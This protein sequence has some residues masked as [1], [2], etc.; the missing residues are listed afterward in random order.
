MITSPGTPWEIGTET[1]PI[2][3]TASSACPPESKSICSSAPPGATGLLPTMSMR[4]GRR[5]PSLIGHLSSV[6]A[7]WHLAS[8]TAEHAIPDIGVQKATASR[9]LRGG[10]M[11]P[12]RASNR[13]LYSS[14]VAC[15]V[16]LYLTDEHRR[17]NST[18]AR[19]GRRL[20]CLP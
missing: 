13:C 15:N 18:E 4:T 14:A 10:P 7:G 12:I 11:H 17:V 6:L 9:F 20:T 16:D 19:T 5:R 8:E 2:L 1:R 3:P